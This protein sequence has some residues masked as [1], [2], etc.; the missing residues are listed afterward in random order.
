MHLR[1]KNAV[2]TRMNNG[3]LSGQVG[4]LLAQAKEVFRQIQEAELCL[5]ENRDRILAR[6]WDL[7]RILTALK[8][9]VGL[10]NWL[11]WLPANFPQLGKTDGAR[12]ENASRCMRFFKENPMNIGN[13]RLSV[14]YE[15]RVYLSSYVPILAREPR[16]LSR[17][18]YQ[19]QCRVRSLEHAEK[20]AN[21]IWKPA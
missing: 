7:G 8:K 12:S 1:C 11:I 18:S 9:E 13:S 17:G 4:P 2:P 5:R 15:P 10:G 3:R 20:K 16:K 6:A 14:R 21:A 19:D